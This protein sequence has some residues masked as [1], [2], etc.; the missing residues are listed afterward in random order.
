MSDGNPTRNA[1][2]KTAALDG[3]AVACIAAKK[4]IEYPG[5]QLVGDARTCIRNGNF[6]LFSEPAQRESYCAFRLIVFDGVIRQIQKQLAQP[7]AVPENHCGLA[8][9][10]GH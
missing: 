9:L 6:R 2:A 7:M 8:V 3:L 5:Q 4:R 1:P 10:E